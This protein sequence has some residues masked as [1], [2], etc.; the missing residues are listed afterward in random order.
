MSYRRG[1]SELFRCERNG[2]RERL[3]YST[4]QREIEQCPKKIRGLQ[5]RMKGLGW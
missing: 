3:I 2:N 4:E 1:N 5:N